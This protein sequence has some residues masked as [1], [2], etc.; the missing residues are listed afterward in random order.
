MRQIHR[1]GRFRSSRRPLLLASVVLLAIAA[2]CEPQDRRPGTWLSG[3]AA[4]EP[5]DD[6]AFVN[7][8]MEVFVE[9]RPWY[10][11]PHSVTTVIAS[12]NGKVFVPSIYETPA[13]FPGTKYWNRIIADNPSVRLKV[14]DSLYEMEATPAADAEEFEEGLSALAEKYDFWR[15]VYEDPDNQ[16]P[17]VI[18]RLRPRV[19]PGAG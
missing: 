5:V 9:T 19:N 10:G 17:F 12:R 14:G 7:D 13:E 16:I 11:V 1:P 3:R 15:N 2:G 6:W 4:V 18:I 8:P